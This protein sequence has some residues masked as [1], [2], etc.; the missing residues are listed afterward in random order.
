MSDLNSIG[1]NTSEQKISSDNNFVV[2]DILN[3]SKLSKLEK[4]FSTCLDD[5]N[6]ISSYTTYVV[7]LV[8]ELN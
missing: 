1:S 8:K 7:V 5:S 6:E 4:E 3:S 2:E